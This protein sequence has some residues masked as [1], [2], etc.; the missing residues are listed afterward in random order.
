MTTGEWFDVCVRDQL[1]L[2]RKP[3]K[4]T[5]RWLVGWRIN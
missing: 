4:I 3:Y 1:E 2:A 5:R